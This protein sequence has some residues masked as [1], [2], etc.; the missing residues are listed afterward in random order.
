MSGSA[1]PMRISASGPA[2]HRLS[3]LQANRL[4]DVALLA[5][6]IADQRD[7]RGAVRIV[8]D[9]RHLARY[10]VLVALEVNQ[11]QLLLVA[12]AMM[13]DG[14]VA[15][16]AASAGALL[17]RQQRLVR[18]VRRDV[19]IH[20]RGLKPQRWCDRSVCLDRHRLALSF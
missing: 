19:V 11:A 13:T 16:V 6:R 2:H 17:D 15:R 20:Q 10:A 12:A 14:Q 4:N 3:N 7:A 9:R 18:L 5:V 1:L 8:L